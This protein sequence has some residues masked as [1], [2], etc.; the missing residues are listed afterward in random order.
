[1]RTQNPGI[2]EVCVIHMYLSNLDVFTGHCHGMLT[3][4]LL[5][6]LWKLLGHCDSY[7]IVIFVPTLV[8][9][10]KLTFAAAIFADTPLTRWFGWSS[11]FNGSMQV[12]SLSLKFSLS[13]VSDCLRAGISETSNPRGGVASRPHFLPWRTS[14]WSSPVLWGSQPKAFLCD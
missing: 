12:V 5:R 1:M 13:A 6:C 14:S 3:T 9:V 11:E 4:F 7:S 2:Y 8:A 10:W